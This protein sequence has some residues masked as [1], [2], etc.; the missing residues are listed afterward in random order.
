MYSKKSN[1]MSF[2]D[3]VL[4]FSGH[5]DGNNR[6]V[7]LAAMI[8]WDMVEEKYASLFNDQGNPAKSVRIALGALIIKEKLGLSDRETVQ[9]IKENPYLQYFL[10]FNEY[11]YVAPFSH[12]LMF[13]FRKRFKSDILNDIN[14]LMFVEKIIENQ[15]DQ[16]DDDSNDD[17]H[18]NNGTLIIDA[19]CAPADIAYPTD[20]NMLNEG[21]EKS[22]K[23]IDILNVFYDKKKPRTYRERARKEYLMVSKRPKA[24]KKTIVKAIKKQLAFLE[25]NLKS[26]D[27]ILGIVSIDV[28]SI[29]QQKQLETI[30]LVS[31][32]QREMLMS[33]KHSVPNRIVSISQPYVRPI[34]RGK[35][36]SKT[37]FGVKFSIS[38]VEGYAF[39][40]Q[41]SFD[42]YNEGEHNQFVAVIELY[43]RR[44]GYYPKRIM[45][46]K[47]YRNRKNLDFCKVHGIRL[48]GPKLGRPTKN[49]LEELRQEG[50][51]CGIRNQVEGKFGEG[52]RKYGMNLIMAK[53]EET[54]KTVIAL[55]LL[56]LNLEKELRFLLRFLGIQWQYILLNA[57][58]GKVVQIVGY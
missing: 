35:S 40:D 6:W 55:Q 22:E 24:G 20:L 10:G 52:K 4:P 33:G 12:S 26:I 53:T 9:Q 57:A 54:N 43:R 38:V 49:H 16:D 56:V 42:S 34:V 13:T 29:R 15:N 32:Q 11:E 3:F 5:L 39:I 44:F 18:P 47:I 31:E 48:S 58:Q 19:S 30:R 8:D 14:E 25:R 1:Q 28:L 27:V 2:Y 45:A 17:D 36:K 37:E 51:D 46:D 41:M 50:K 21:R 23:I 7:Q